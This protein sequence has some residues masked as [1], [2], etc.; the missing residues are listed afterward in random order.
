M[1]IETKNDDDLAFQE[2][3]ATIVQVIDVETR[4]GDKVVANLNSEELGDFSVF[5]NNF[6]MEKLI[7]AYGNDDK[8]FIG[9]V[10]QLEKQTDDTFN[11]EMIVLNPVE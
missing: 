7:K 10:V 2:V 9:K 11:K 3:R 6:S 4:F 1:K 8:N 5:V